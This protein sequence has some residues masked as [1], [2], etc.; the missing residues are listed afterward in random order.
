MDGDGHHLR[1]GSSREPCG[2]E[3]K[4]ASHQEKHPPGSQRKPIRCF[5]NHLSVPFAP[6]IARYATPGPLTTPRDRTCPAQ[7]TGQQPATARQTTRIS[8]QKIILRIIVVRL[9]ADIVNRYTLISKQKMFPLRRQASGFRTPEIKS[10]SFP[11]FQMGTTGGASRQGA[12]PCLVLTIP[13]R[14]AK[15]I[16]AAKGGLLSALSLRPSPWSLIFQNG[17]CINF[18]QCLRIH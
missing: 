15:R 9:R 12:Q 14:P 3:E 2:S 8:S 11:L 4:K 6:G 16:S 7:R 5:S 17:Y 13:G 1:P 10:P 18:N